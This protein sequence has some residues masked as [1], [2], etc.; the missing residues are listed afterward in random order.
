ML[1]D[2]VLTETADDRYTAR[3]VLFPELVVSGSNETDVLQ[4]MQKAISRVHTRSRIMRIDVP[5]STANVENPWLRFAGM[6]VD[7]PNWEAFE[8][9]VA[10]NRCHCASVEL[11]CCNAK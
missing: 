6:W 9:E 4:Q 2:V 3:A 7:D 11:N 8:A 5:N 10:A 1:Y